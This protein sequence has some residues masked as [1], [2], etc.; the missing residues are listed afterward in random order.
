MTL[1]N[2]SI[3]LHWNISNSQSVQRIHN[4]QYVYLYI[5]LMKSM[6]NEWDY[7][8]EKTTIL[9]CDSNNRFKYMPVLILSSSHYFSWTDPLITWYVVVTCCCLLLS[10][11]PMLLCRLSS[12]HWHMS[13]GRGH[14]GTM[15]PVCGYSRTSPPTLSSLQPPPP[16]PNLSWDLGH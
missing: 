11:A 1:Q 13:S 5:L 9:Y 10:A 15:E 14:A 2:P 12:A 8:R 6:N 4:M 3:G 16:A 7:K